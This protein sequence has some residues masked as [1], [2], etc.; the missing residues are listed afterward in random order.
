[1]SS[2]SQ[3]HENDLISDFDPTSSHQCHFAPQIAGLNPLLIVEVPTFWTHPVIEEVQSFVLLEASITLPVDL[4]VQSQIGLNLFGNVLGEGLI[5]DRILSL[6]CHC[7]LIHHHSL[8][9]IRLR[10]LD[11]CILV[12]LLLLLTLRIF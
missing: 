5:R 8:I 4:S 3:K 7:W 1:M 12:L 10:I 2:V 11:Y 9:R 6:S